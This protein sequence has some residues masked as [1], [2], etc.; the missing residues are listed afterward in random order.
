MSNLF[1]QARRQFPALRTKTFLDAAC[2]SLAPRAAT[3]AI[4]QFLR[5]AETCPSPSATDHHLWMDGEREKTRLEAARLINAQADEIALVESTTYGLSVAAQVVPFRRGDNVVLADTEFLQVA[6]P[7]H[8][9]GLEIKPVHHQRGRIRA[10]DIEAALDRRTRAVVISSVQWSSGFR[11]DLAALSRLCRD[12]RVYLVVDAV[13]HLG[14]MPLDVQA[15]PVDFLAC[16]GH[17]WLNA[18]FG[19]GLLYVRREVMDDLN[20]F[21]HGY[22]S[23]VP[24]DGGWGDYFQTPAISPYR[25]YEFVSA[26]KKFEAGGTSNYPGAIGLGAS[27]RLINRLGPDAIERHIRRLTDHLI[28][29]LRTLRARIVTPLEAAHR[30]GIVT[31]RF[32]NSSRKE[33]ALVERLLSQQILV[34]RRYTSGVGGI[35][36]SCHF[37]NTRDDLDRLLN[38]VERAKSWTD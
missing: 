38:A 36:V 11:C 12:R 34:S 10:E 6:V 8:Q 2:V 21:V 5:A 26:A 33:L 31:F 4:Q 14:A 7:W 25:D 35:R 29:G 24:P 20:P 28:E 16:G 3:R 13:Q 17:K 37:F 19:A 1:N 27:L 23:V 9:R 30:S 15:T 18:P 32:S 22:L